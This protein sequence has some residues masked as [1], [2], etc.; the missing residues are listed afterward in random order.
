VTLYHWD[1]PQALEEQGGWLQRDVADRFAEYTTAVVAR[2]SDRVRHWITINE[3]QVFLTHGYLE[4]RHAPGRR[5]SLSEALQASHHVLLAHG[6]SAAAIRSAAR[7]SPSV[8]LAIVGVV[9]M[10]KTPRPQDVAAARQA[11]LAVQ[12]DNLFN[13]TWWLDPVVTGAYPADGLKGYGD[14]APMVAEGDMKWI[15]QPLDFIG[16]NVYRG[17]WVQAGPDGQPIIGPHEV[18]QRFTASGWQVTPESLHWG[19]RF[20]YEHY[21]LPIVIAE[22][23]MANTDWVDLDGQVHDPQRID[24]IRRHL[25]ELA[26]AIA[27]GTDVCG[28]FYWSLLD[29]FEWAEGYRERFGLVHVD[30]ETQQRRLKDSA[31]WYRTVIESGGAAIEDCL[32]IAIADPAR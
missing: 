12:A 32:Q 19:P 16:L 31:Y 9:C 3:P 22:N 6:K 17:V 8:G 21:G 18:G 13:N 30:F 14:R 25:R 29:N 7:V 4:G 15:Q 2:L 11:T 23:G 5:L 20:I 27:H 24:F 1:L 28:Y 26:R 10:P